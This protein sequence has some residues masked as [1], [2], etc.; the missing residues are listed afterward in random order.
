MYRE[1]QDVRIKRNLKYVKRLSLIALILCALCTY[2]YLFWKWYL[3]DWMISHP[4]DLSSSYIS[5]FWGGEEFWRDTLDPYKTADLA[6][7]I[8]W[9][10]IYC[11]GYFEL[12]IFTY[13]FSKN[14]AQKPFVWRMKLQRQARFASNNEMKE[15][16]KESSQNNDVTRIKI[17]I[18]VNFIPVAVFVVMIFACIIALMAGTYETISDDVKSVSYHLGGMLLSH[19]FLII[20]S[21][22][23][24]QNCVLIKREWKTNPP[25]FLL[26]KQQQ[27]AEER[28]KAEEE[29]QKAEE[30]AQKQKQERDT[31]TCKALLEEC[32]MQFFIEYYPQIQRLP[33]RDVTVSDHYFPERQVRLSA[34]KKIVDSGLTECALHYITETFGDVFSSEI[35]EQAKTILNEI[36]NKKGEQNENN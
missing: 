3:Y 22:F 32:G 19:L 5:L 16:Y 2:T 20:S 35:I 9:D 23:L 21:G 13:F 26:E 1:Y 14:F 12:A 7:E 15:S 34:A 10:F 24:I 36:E 4:N 8:T 11:L 33:I 27:A 18:I 28:Q 25:P 30:E 29:R 17:Y 31:A 6:K